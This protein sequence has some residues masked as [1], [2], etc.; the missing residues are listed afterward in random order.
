MEVPGELAKVQE[1][2]RVRFALREASAGD[3]G[4]LLTLW[5][6]AAEND[7][8]PPDTPE[9]VAALLGRDAG[10]A[11]VAEHSGQLIGSVIAGWDGWRCHLYRLAVRPDWRRQGVGAALLGAAE[12]RFRALGA[13][14]IDAM[15][16]DSNELGQRLWRASGYRQ[17]EDWR[18]WVKE[19]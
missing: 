17:Q 9:A 4:G 18:R 3:V 6:A 8:R 13:T 15:V 7:S 1:N 16:L 5:A 11:I 12:S 2:G 19:L 14:R 10:A